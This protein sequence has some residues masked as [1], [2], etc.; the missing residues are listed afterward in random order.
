MCVCERV[1]KGVGGRKLCRYIRKGKEIS[2]ERE[3]NREKHGRI[4]GGERRR[5]GGVYYFKTERRK[6]RNKIERTKREL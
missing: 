2:G 3:G 6:Q 4:C 5:G 1:S